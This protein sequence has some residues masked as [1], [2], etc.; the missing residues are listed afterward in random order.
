[1]GKRKADNGG[2]AVMEPETQALQTSAIPLDLIWPPEQQPRTLF[3]EDSLHN[4]AESLK[5]NGQIQ[6]I[7]VK[8]LPAPEGD[9]AGI[10]HYEYEILWGE[11][12]WR[13][14]QLLGWETIRAE[15]DG[16]ALADDELLFRQLAENADREN[17]NAIEEGEAYQR[18]V[19]AKHTVKEI[20]ERIHQSESHVYTRLK[21]VEALHDNVKEALAARVITAGHAEILCRL[22]DSAQIR[23]ERYLRS[24]EWSVRELRRWVVQEYGDKETEKEVKAQGTAFTNGANMPET[25]RDEDD[26]TPA[27]RAEVMPTAA[28]A[29]EQ[30][31]ADAKPIER[32]K[33][34]R[35]AESTDPVSISRTADQKLNED[36]RRRVLKAFLYSAGFFDGAKMLREWF[37]AE[38]QTFANDYGDEAVEVAKLVPG[39]DPKMSSYNELGFGRVAWAMRFAG[40]IFSPAPGI[41]KDL[42]EAARAAGVNTQAL[43]EE[44][45]AAE[46]GLSAPKKPKKPADKKKAKKLSVA[47]RAQK[48]VKA[49]AKAKKTKAAKKKTK[50]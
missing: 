19:D 8:R 44:A 20:A 4:L 18:L 21:F 36:W 32:R 37:R 43:Y 31:A 17:L 38:W 7:R 9:A 25:D 33:E 10:D 42:L 23:A 28:E 34:L 27:Q 16:E 49:I 48:R 35:Q 13:A 45:R 30:L 41:P 12:R 11:R 50:K 47:M 26:L 15:I 22:E 6:P 3:D 39:F 5:T 1:M 24:E 40:A 14:A 29:G 2:A 46:A